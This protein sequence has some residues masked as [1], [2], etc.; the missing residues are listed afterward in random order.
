[1]T[2]LSPPPTLPLPQRA[3]LDGLL[4]AAAALLPSDPGRAL[5]LST[6][7]L[8]VTVAS[9]PLGEAQ[10]RLGVGQALHRLAQFQE[11]QEELE[12]AAAIYRRCG[13]AAGQA[14]SLITLGKVSREL[15]EPARAS[16]HLTLA[17]ELARAAG[18]V[19][20][21]AEAL[22][23]QAV[24]L[25]MSGQAAPSLECFRMAL[26]LREDLGDV[27]GTAQVLNNIGQVHL[28]QLQ[29]G[30]ALLALQ[31]AFELLADLNDPVLSAQCLMTIAH[32]YEDIDDLAQ[33]YDHHRR[34]YD[35]GRTGG[36]RLV[37]LYSLNNLAGAAFHLAKHEEARTLFTR[38]LELAGEVGQRY[39]QGCAHHGLG[40]AECV[41]GDL[42]RALEH[43]RQALAIASELGDPAGEVDAR[44]GLGETY[45]RRGEI[46]Q[47]IEQLDLALPLAQQGEQHR[48]VVE[49]HRLL[50]QAHERA[51]DLRQ[52]V[53]HLRAQQA[54][55]QTL[56]GE[57]R[58][59]QTRQL[60]VQFDVER[61]HH[62]A[63]LY[64]MR[65]ETTQRAYEEAEARVERRTRELARAQVEV[66]TRLANAAEF[67]DDVT[68]EH[69]LRVGQVAA[70]LGAQLGLCADEVALLR[71]AARLH[72]VGK[73]GISDLILL[74][75]D[76]LTSDEFERM[77][78]HTLIGSQI[79]SGGDSRLLQMA[80]EIALSHH[81]HWAGGGYP[82]RLIGAAIPLSARIVAVA[83]VY[84]ALSHQR[85]YKRPWTTPEVLAELQR[86]SGRQFQPEI[87]AALMSLHESG[88]LPLRS[89]GAGDDQVLDILVRS[90]AAADSE[91]GLAGVPAAQD[92]QLLAEHRA[93]ESRYAQARDEIR[94]LQVAAF[95]DA[96]TGLAN[97]RAF[98]ADLESA[99][100]QAE[101]HGH[102]LGVLSMDLDGLKGLNDAQGHDQGDALLRA[103]S[104]ALQEQFAPHGRLYRIG[105]DEFALIAPQLSGQA[106]GA[107]QLGLQRGMAEVR[108]SGFPH[109]AVSFG[110]A[111]YPDE[112][113]T[114]GD[115]VRL[116]D[117]RMYLQKASRRSPPLRVTLH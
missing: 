97:R 99:L 42:P 68:G 62:E 92:T 28:S 19:P 15:G 52:T 111:T 105:G 13:N 14:A 95:T 96:L 98:E 77:K 9:E 24:L 3:H 80:Q 54:L 41:L 86:Q 57:Q 47:A 11:A 26:S 50:A 49:A 45:L 108:R 46:F 39:L 83:D 51:G 59:R 90:G 100:V 40:Q 37:E 73:I 102:L 89:L 17:L 64:R 117:Q 55:T 91:N 6:E 75:P 110:L 112:A 34:A 67:R 27:A 79:L 44:L 85:P 1:M 72:D 5:E 106:V 58:E 93:L 71:L 33:A 38:A 109:A 88:A 78:A 30:E 22:N 53:V 23:Q 36:N 66:L 4:S 113:S 61:A 48:A 101:R 20:L 103:V 104:H 84:D 65:T 29:H 31:R 74:K 115:V 107:L 76:R 114:Q 63:E 94:T 56:A 16:E 70:L 60:T 8:R 10:A 116:S 18:S 69:T 87:I 43:H 12:V 2:I 81:E 32:V 25:Q 21:E 7:A 35:L 82:A